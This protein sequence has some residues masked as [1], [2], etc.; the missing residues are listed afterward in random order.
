[1][2]RL[3]YL[4]LMGCMLLCAGCSKQYSD[5]DLVFLNVHQ[6]DVVVTTPESSLFS[7]AKDNTFLDPRT[8]ERYA[9]G[10][11]PGAINVPYSRVAETWESLQE[12]GVIVVYG[13][14]Y[15]DPLAEAMSKTLME[16]GLHDIKTLKGGL[17]A[18]LNDGQDLAKGRKP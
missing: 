3:T 16:Y 12:Y 8:A 2:N 18:W 9:I 13:K 10:H 7:T 17:E 6:A 1:M 11:I 14:T 4:I 15:N 5:A